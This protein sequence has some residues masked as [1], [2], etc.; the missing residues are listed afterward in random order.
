MISLWEQK[1]PSL[2]RSLLLFLIF[3]MEA[4]QRLA[5]NPACLLVFGGISALLYVLEALQ[6]KNRF[7]TLSA[8]LCCFFIA[9]FTIP[10]VLWESFVSQYLDWLRAPVSSSPDTTWYILI[11]VSLLALLSLVYQLLADRFFALQLLTASG[12]LLWMG[13]DLFTRRTITHIGA[14]CAFGYIVVTLVIL[15]D[16]HWP[17]HRCETGR[18]Y[19]LWLL[20]FLMAYLLLMG[21]TPAPERPYDWQFV[22]T[23][24][25]QLN[26]GYLL[27]KQEI[28]QHNQESFTTSLSGFGKDS[29]FSEAIIEDDSLVMYLQGTNSLR[30]NLYLTGKVYDHFDGRQWSRTDSLKE[31]ETKLD[32]LETLCAVRLYDAEHETDY[33]R[34]TSIQVQYENFHSRYLFSPLKTWKVWSNQNNYTNTTGSLLFDDFQGYGTTY[35]TYYLQL[36]TGHDAFYDFLA[37][38]IPPDETVWKQVRREYST[39]YEQAPTLE[40]FK[41]HQNNIHKVYT[42]SYLLS[43]KTQL[44]RTDITKDAV[45]DIHKLR[46]IEAY[47]NRMEYTKSPGGLP[48]HV[49]SPEAFLEYFL[50]ESKRGYCSHFATAFVLLARAEGFPARYVEGFCVPVTDKQQIPV[51]NSMAHAWPEVYL[52][53]IGWIPFEPTPGFESIRYTPWEPTGTQI[54][55]NGQH[56]PSADTLPT[57]APTLPAPQ[58]DSSDDTATILPVVSFF[59]LLLFCMGILIVLADR[60]VQ[61]YRYRKWNLSRRFQAQIQQNLQIL[62]LLGY[63]RAPNE[64]L[65]ELRERAKIILNEEALEFLSLF[66]EVL[67][68]HKEVNEQMLQQVLAEQTCLL[69]A[70]KQSKYPAYLYYQI[71]KPPGN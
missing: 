66:E 39:A 70:L 25:Q 65:W 31:R 50:T 32:A 15:T 26:Q 59:L 33:L 51:Y 49:D 18:P 3:L 35:Q 7:L 27:I 29:G 16:K 30:S 56:T 1:L 40:D 67:Y 48:G 45:S 54:Q 53:N 46:A 17:K 4:G 34:S 11:T 69:A 44:L 37:S 14:T 20:P 63:R 8:L 23:L 36:N 22:K 62:A 41:N 57:P 58:E 38:S 10:D 64:T 61:R 9:A 24:Y 21:I 13:V 52:E 55:Q 19:L 47:L 71:I 42:D 60:T 5:W 28:T 12:L 6:K 43:T 68:N 2:F